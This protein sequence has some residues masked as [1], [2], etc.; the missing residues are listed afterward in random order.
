[1]TTA[2]RAPADPA[3]RRQVHIGTVMAAP[4]P[5]RPVSRHAVVITAGRV[6][7]IVPAA[8][9]TALGITDAD[10]DIDDHG[11]RL[12]SPGFV[13]AHVHLGQVGLTA[14]SLDLHDTASLADVLDAV[15]ERAQTQPTGTVVGLGWDDSG[16]TAGGRPPTA[17]DL[18]VVAPGRLVYLARVDVHSAVASPSLLRAAGA[19]GLDGY[20]PA[21]RVARA[22][23][24]AVRD[25]IAAGR[26]RDERRADLVSALVTA[27]DR[28]VVAVHEL[29]APHLSDPDDMALLADLASARDT[30][31]V[32]TYWGEHADTGGIAT[33]GALGCRG[34]AGDLSADGAIG[35]RTAALAHD[36]S[37]APGHR[38]S[39]YLD[40]A[41][42]YRHLRACTEARVQAGFHCIGDA[43]VDAVL[44]GFRDVVAD[45]GVDAVRACRHRIEH[46]ELWPGTAS[47]RRRSA[48]DLAEWG[49]VASMQPEFDGWWGGAGG[50][51]ERRLG[52][53]RAAGMNPLRTLHDAG[54]ALAFGSDA[55]VTPI[56]PWA[57]VRAAVDHHQESERLDLASALRAHTVGGWYAAGLSESE[58]R[59]EGEIS[60][61]NPANL[62]VWDVPDVASAL[63]AV[64]PP[65]SLTT[66]RAGRVLRTG[67]AP[68]A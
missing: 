38:G 60:P 46:L 10:A 62:V 51:Y 4:T 39:L 56:A 33:A 9:L 64:D 23:H 57:G 35:S 63:A 25:T 36:Y 44:R 31:D 37:D 1:M 22:A 11:D 14:A 48:G 58:A 28:G 42:T 7:A 45:L 27:A 17:A 59:R 43:A 41:A 66:L 20:G 13:D 21:G 16:W 65:R 40:A 68:D 8:A 26:T 47:D 12:I 5:T 52:V 50:L 34:A 67:G 3:Q 19:V 15:R 54:V 53:G 30:P 61:G 55:P 24:H 18:D 2:R 6:E 49:V 29:G 32:T